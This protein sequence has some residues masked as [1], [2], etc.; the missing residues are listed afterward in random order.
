MIA[1]PDFNNARGEA[2]SLQ[3]S[4]PFEFSDV[5]MTVFP[6]EANLARLTQFTESYLN[7]APDIVHFKPF[8]P[9]VY[10][11]ILDYGKM[12]TEA[13][14][15]GWVSQREVAF[16]VPLQWMK[17]TP[18]GLKFHDWA[19]TTPFIFVDNEL[20]LST[21][22]EVYG[23]PKL[24]AHLDPRVDE[25]VQDPHGARRV[26]EIRSQAAANRHGH[27]ATSPFLS[28]TQTQVSGMTDF[29][30][31]LT[32][33]ADALRDM[34]STMFG[35]ARM[36][37]DA[38]GAMRTMLEARAEGAKADPTQQQAAGATVAN[39]MASIFPKLYSNTI[40]LKQFRDAASPEGTCY[41]AITAAK[42]PIQRVGGGGLLGAQNMMVGQLSGGFEVNITHSSAVPIVSALGLQAN[43]VQSINGDQI[44]TISP[45]CP[46]WVKLD[47]HYGKGETLA[48]RPRQGAWRG[49]DGM[50]GVATPT[51][52]PAPKVANE[53]PAA[54]DADPKKNPNPDIAARLSGAATSAKFVKVDTDKEPEPE[55][56]PDP[57]PADD[58]DP[59]RLPQDVQLIE[60][61]NPF[62]TTRG[63]SEAIGGKLRLPGAQIR[64]LP[65]LADPEVLQRFVENYIQVPG[66]LRVELWGRHV[67]L[68]VS[69]FRRMMADLNPGAGGS[70]REITFSV[71]VKLYDISG[72]EGPSPNT[73]PDWV[74]EALR[75][76]WQRGADGL[77][78]TALISP[79]SYVD[80]M[81][82]AISESEVFG[83]PTLR[84]DISSPP[85]GWTDK[86]A[87]LGI[88]AEARAI[89]V[90][91]LGTNSEGTRQSLVQVREFPMLPDW[92][93]PGWT[94]LAGDWG[95][96]LRDDLLEK[97]TQS[98]ATR[99]DN[100]AQ[101]D[102]QEDK[103][104][105]FEQSPEFPFNAARALSLTL[106]GGTNGINT[107]ALKQFR[108]A[109]EPEKACYQG[110]VMKTMRIDTIHTLT[111][112]E[113]PL[114]VA[115]T[116]FP[117][118]PIGE[119]LGLIPKRTANTPQGLVDEYEPLRPFEL[120]G[121][122][123]REGGKT[124]FERGTDADWTMVYMASGTL[125]WRE[126]K[127]EDLPVLLG[128]SPA[129]RICYAFCP[130]G[131]QTIQ[132]YLP[133][134]L[135]SDVL[136]EFN[137]LKQSQVLHDLKIL[138]RSLPLDLLCTPEILDRM[139]EGDVLS[140][141]T[142]LS[143]MDVDCDAVGALIETQDVAGALELINPATVLD[144]IL[145]RGWANPDGDRLH[146]PRSDYRVRGDAFG[147][148][149][150]QRLFPKVEVQNGFWPPSPDHELQAVRKRVSRQTL[151]RYE[152]WSVIDT[153]GG[154]HKRGA[155]KDMH[156]RDIAEIQLPDWFRPF[157]DSAPTLTLP[158][159]RFFEYWD[160]AH[161]QMLKKGMTA[162]FRQLEYYNRMDHDLEIWR[163]TWSRALNQLL[164][165]E[166][167]DGPW[168]DW[169]TGLEAVHLLGDRLSQ[170]GLV[171][172][173]EPL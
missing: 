16:G 116:R 30:P 19:F 35:M 112:I 40:N 149:V 104:A 165:E 133:R 137:A 51:P 169:P 3:M 109:G 111:E 127:P 55:T 26:F 125:G 4:P 123:I 171:P 21:G 114:S 135:T 17:P 58:P 131:S 61:S 29:P 105:S 151:L 168:R 106:L 158:H 53:K 97:F 15:T 157:G 102:E 150:S 69:N 63:A 33:M 36:W 145:N 99:A 78:G 48:W 129:P 166:D 154:E 25:W 134:D 62:N 13:A 130:P 93:T 50:E 172:G 46:F 141:P 43:E 146:V 47:M 85:R 23:W 95:G 94:E 96:Y 65:L 82:A 107:L 136:N 38:L 86:R 11:I 81:R 70:A 75:D 73:P 87:D 98:G 101:E 100:E 90:P 79:F 126:T 147:P 1:G 128:E 22:R 57:V 39:S 49:I 74:P 76:N 139:D 162:F 142:L 28:V 20:S 37:R 14:R 59:T 9:Y 7:Q 164:R 56:K 84:S 60:P 83:I 41:Q 77:I 152:F 71:P 45:V 115:I 118:Q 64:V 113:R 124:L 67:Y 122:L 66:K 18:E 27:E 173:S 143:T 119:I 34:P 144:A 108:D 155:G 52:A 89:V 72:E 68:S 110:I 148:V 159:V 54:F 5:T 88:L 80:D 140:I 6:L 167:E 121:D 24:L 160:R 92:D 91:S 10:L 156:L 44:A 170:I 32:P 120:T 31:R 117:T 138:R 153:L 8:L 103:D 163:D 12:S 161:V 42:M 132:R 2:S